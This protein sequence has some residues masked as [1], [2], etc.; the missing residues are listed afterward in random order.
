MMDDTR[1]RAVTSVA[2][3]AIA[4]RGHDGLGTWEFFLEEFFVGILLSF[5]HAV[6]QV[7]RHVRRLV[8][9]F[10]QCA[11]SIVTQLTSIFP[12][13]EEPL[14]KH[15]NESGSFDSREDSSVST[16]G[17]SETSTDMVREA[18]LHEQEKS[19]NDDDLLTSMKLSFPSPAEGLAGT[20][21]TRDEWGHFA[22]FREE[23]ADE[24]CFIPSCAGAVASRPPTATP[25]PL[26]T[27]IAQPQQGLQGLSALAT[28]PEECDDDDE[29]EDSDW[30]F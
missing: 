16:N 18:I 10:H 4:T 9:D 23:L 6:V 25:A 11:P 26:M 24:A 28:L 5:L 13:F 21:T 29:E 15:F 14:S 20:A 1:G 2:G 8:R 17:L 12:K 7:E 27:A 22:D 19:M 30:S 3:A